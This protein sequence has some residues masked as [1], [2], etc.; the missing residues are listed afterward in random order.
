MTDVVIV[1]G[2]VIGLS[3]GYE[4]AGQGVSVKILEQRAFGR[5]ASW[6]GAGI[7]PP[8]NP[9]QAESPMARL[10]AESAATWPALSSELLEATGIDNGFRNCGG[11]QLALSGPATQL[12]DEMAEWAF[13]GVEAV[14]WSPE[15]LSS[16]EPAVNSAVVAAYHLPGMSQ[17]RNPRH[18][19]AL[20]SGCAE[21]GVELVPG[22]PVVGFDRTGDK[23]IAALTPG[24]AH[25]AGQFCICGGAW[26]RSLLEEA[27]VEVM[28]EPIR[29]QIVQLSAQPLPF[30]RVIEV[31]SRYL[32]PRPDGLILVGSTEERAGFNARPTG[33]GVAGLLEFAT[34]VV[35]ALSEAKFERAWA[36]LRPGS[37]DRVPFIGAVPGAEN[38]YV[39][40][41]HF[42]AG[43]QQSPGTALLLRQLMLG[44]EPTIPLDA[45]SCDRSRVSSASTA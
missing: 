21:R 9:K 20:I 27:G 43:L 7:L 29:G 13:E 3:A 10:R 28:I 40:A 33:A 6:A 24:G 15:E 32:V 2:G 16:R 23:C 45:F 11:L 19:K 25:H 12:H 35:P 4:L 36:G 17:V 38:L 8:G 5:E 14:E 42:R 44:Q 37:P 34:E 1:G 39:A 22:Q 30:R 41:G 31:G 18:I 26:S